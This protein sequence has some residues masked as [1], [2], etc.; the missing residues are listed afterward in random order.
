[1]SKAPAPG[2]P[3]ALRLLTPPLQDDR[4]LARL[5][6]VSTLT[7]ATLAAVAAA[8][9]AWAGGST[10]PYAD[11]TTLTRSVLGVPDSTDFPPPGLTVAVAGALATAA[12]AAVARTSRR[13]RARQLARLVTM[14]AAAV[15][16]VRGIGGYAQ[17]LL[18]PGAATPEFTRNDLLIYSPLCLALAAGLAILEK[19]TKTEKR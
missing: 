1:M 4:T 11:G 8:H 15:L 18:A 12:V 6:P 7:A 3:A 19:P 2:G 16:A 10:W 14:P 17:S 9:V 5:R 13:P